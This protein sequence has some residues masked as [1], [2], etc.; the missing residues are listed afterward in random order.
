MSV[1]RGGLE[2]AASCV[3]AVGRRSVGEL[4]GDMVEFSAP[5]LGKEGFLQIRLTV[6]IRKG[7]E[8]W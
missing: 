7:G 8:S 4:Q 2:R 6:R 3:V 5:S 1:N